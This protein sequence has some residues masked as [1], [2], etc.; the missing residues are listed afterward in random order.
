V[1]KNIL[2]KINFNNISILF[3]YGSFL[4]IVFI[5]LL[6]SVTY[7]GVLLN[8]IGIKLST[9]T[10]G[11]SVVYLFSYFK[12]NLSKITIKKSKPLLFFSLLV[13]STTLTLSLIESFTYPNFVFSKIHLNYKALQTLSS[14]LLLFLISPI[15]SKIFLH[16]IF[17]TKSKILVIGLLFLTPIFS[18]FSW[19]QHLSTNNII[20]TET[21]LFSDT[22]GSFVFSKNELK[23]KAFKDQI[24]WFFKPNNSYA[25]IKIFFN[26]FTISFS[27]IFLIIAILFFINWLQNKKSSKIGFAL[28]TFYIGGIAYSILITLIS[29]NMFSVGELKTFVGRYI[30]TYVLALIMFSFYL[31]LIN[32]QKN[33]KINTSIL[34]YMSLILITIN[35]PSLSNLK[36]NK[37]LFSN[38]QKQEFLYQKIKDYFKDKDRPTIHTIGGEGPVAYRYFFVP[39]FVVSPIWQDWDV[40]IFENSGFKTVNYVFLASASEV[41]KKW[42]NPKF[43]KIFV[44]KKN[45]VDN[46]LYK[47]IYT[48]DDRSLFQFELINL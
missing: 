40:F 18:Y 21:R 30:L 42:S 43:Q 16:K 29:V 11:L 34:I 44:D 47:V 12:L 15:I 41:F 28:L 19:S 8:K 32:F 2:Q 48:T 24:Y 5:C 35:I 9:L 1:L 14:F 45:V 7:P 36:P 46:G 26:I 17:N 33:K 23:E 6:E 25:Q 38:R 13:I 4:I 22:K 20:E 31:F 3:L 37:Q 10:L 27:T 39:Y